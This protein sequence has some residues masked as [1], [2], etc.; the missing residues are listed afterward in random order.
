[1]S[2]GYP[3]IELTHPAVGSPI[4]DIATPA[5]LVD[6]DLLERNIAAM[7]SFFR[8]RPARLR[9]HAKTHRAPAVARMQVEAGAVGVTCAKVS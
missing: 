6:L 3:D 7:A 9:P 4:A 5:L 2:T 8:D 1:M